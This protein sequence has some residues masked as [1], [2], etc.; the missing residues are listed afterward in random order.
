M[1]ARAGGGEPAAGGRE[2]VGRARRAGQHHRVVGPQDARVARRDEH[3]SRSFTAEDATVIVGTVIDD[4]MED[5]LRVTMVATGL[6]GTQL[7]AKRPPKLEVLESAQ[8]T[9]RTGTDGYGVHVETIDYDKLDQP[10]VVRRRHRRRP[11]PSQQ[12]GRLRGHPGVPAQAGR[13]SE[14]R[15]AQADAEARSARRRAR[16]VG[17]RCDGQS[18]CGTFPY[19]GRRAE[20]FAVLG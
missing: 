5:Q 15:E 19:D 6:G 11:A 18:R 7:Q 14:A 17:R 13:L 4:Q 16:E 20:R 1:A 8:V 12:H 2:P 9:S 10:A 3:R